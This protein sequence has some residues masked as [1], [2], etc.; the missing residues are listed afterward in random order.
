MKSVKDQAKY[1]I[2]DSPKKNHISKSYFVYWFLL[3]IITDLEIVFKRGC[4]LLLI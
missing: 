3:M 4:P 1:S 2:K